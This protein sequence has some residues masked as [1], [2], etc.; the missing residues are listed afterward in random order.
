MS[1]CGRPGRALRLS[2]AQQEKRYLRA[3]ID[4]TKKK[5]MLQCGGGTSALTSPLQR[6]CAGALQGKF[7]CQIKEAFSPWAR[8]PSPCPQ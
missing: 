8:P 6:W 4:G 3:Q 1:S 7:C 2:K 5:L